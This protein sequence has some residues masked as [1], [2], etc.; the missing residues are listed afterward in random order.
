MLKE[1]E[2]RIACTW[3]G[4]GYSTVGQLGGGGGGIVRLIPSFYYIAII[5]FDCWLALF[6]FV[7]VGNTKW[8]SHLVSVPKK[9][10][11][12]SKCTDNSD[13]GVKNLKFPPTHGVIFL[14]PAFLLNCQIIVPT[15]K[16]S[17][18]NFCLGLRW[19]FYSVNFCLFK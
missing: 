13:F 8:S 15:F 17:A 6:R 2:P 5:K 11:M 18:E 12:F 4:V 19:F 9:S 1:P 10:R 14:T 3:L 16:E 7:L